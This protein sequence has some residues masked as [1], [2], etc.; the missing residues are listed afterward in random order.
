MQ[1]GH[2][3]RR[4]PPLPMSWGTKFSITPGSEKSCKHEDPFGGSGACRLWE[5]VRI[6]GINAMRLGHVRTQENGQLQAK[7]GLSPGTLI[8]DFPAPVTVR[9]S[10]PPSLRAPLRQTEQAKASILFPGEAV[11]FS[12]VFSQFPS[13]VNWVFQLC[14]SPRLGRAH[15]TA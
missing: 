13:S 9:N 12:K 11:L 2:F 4:C 3:S 7:R 14:L 1:E 15:S 8:L 5:K 10:K 6:R